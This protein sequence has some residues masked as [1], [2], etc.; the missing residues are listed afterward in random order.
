MDRKDTKIWLLLALIFITIGTLTFATENWLEQRHSANQRETVFNNIG[1]SRARL[2]S[3]L[4]Q[5]LY[6]L[7]ALSTYIGLHPNISEQEYTRY[8][9]SSLPSNSVI[10]I[11]AA[12]PELVVKYIYPYVG[13]EQAIGLNYREHRDQREAVF[14]AIEQRDSVLAGPVE[15]VQGGTGFVARVPVFVAAN[16]PPADQK[17]WGIVAA[18]IPE[19]ILYAESGF[20][21]NEQ[22]IDIALRGRDASGP[23]G[24]VFFGD[25]GLFDPSA[26]SILL[27]IKVASGE[28]Q[29]AAQPIGGWGLKNSGLVWS[30][31]AGGLMIAIGLFLGFRHRQKLSEQTEEA[32]RNFEN[33][34]EM[35]N[36]GLFINDVETLNILNM[37]QSGLRQL[38]YDPGEMIG[39]SALEFAPYQGVEDILAARETLSQQT[40]IVFET[41]L[42]R[43]DGT[44]V[45]VELSTRKVSRPDGDIAISA[46]RDISERKAVEA[47]LKKSRQDLISAIEAINAG[48]ALW[49]PA[50]KLQIFNQ[51]YINLNP[52]LKEKVKVGIS[53]RELLAYTYDMELVSTDF[54]RDE[55]IEMRIADHKDPKGPYEFR[56]GDGRFVKISEYLTPDGSCVAIYEDITELKRATEHVHYRAYFDVLTGLPNRE[57]FLG[58]LTETLVAIQRTEQ[59][60][61]LLFVDLDRFKN[62]NDT[63]GHAIGDNLL[64]E[65][66]LRLRVVVRQTDFVA[67]FA[68]DEFVV[69]LRYIEEPI[70]AAHIAENL[71]AKLSAPYQVD[72]HE[73]YCSA[74]IGIAV[75]PSDTLEAETLL[76]YADLAMYQAKA[77]GGNAFRFFTANMTERAQ[78]F[79][80]IEKDLRQAIKEDQCQLHYQPVFDLRSNELCSVEALVRWEHPDFGLMLPDEFISIAE[81]TSFIDE[82]GRWV[83]SEATKKAIDWRNRENQ[84][85]I[86]VAVNV[87]SRQFWG[88]FDT[89]FVRNLLAEA[90]FPAERLNIEIT[91]SIVMGDEERIIRVLEDLR[92]LG[93]GIC[94]DDFGTGYSA[95]SYLKRLPV[96]MLKIDRS[97]VTD[98][99]KSL[100]DA[101]LVE[102]IIAMAKALRVRVVAEGIETEPQLKILSEMGCDFGQGL[103]FGEPI[104]SLEFRKRFLTPNVVQLNDR[105]RGSKR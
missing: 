94:I 11:V 77:I 8:V 98:I 59:V 10:S 42:R 53:F 105:H 91:E 34:F 86:Q 73:V 40:Q 56:S 52:Q 74:S 54:Q 45:P 67:R 60:A 2:E 81:E 72:G 90:D 55:W 93:V 95:I 51:R 21:S 36:D 25:A 84:K 102:S 79:V 17:L 66:A 18:V 63:L 33:L 9:A 100:D 48:F 15:L 75:A 99:E 49:D 89:R 20:A 31:R 103:L 26:E 19:E 3:L 78:R 50:G 57:N 41:L 64:R 24:P 85:P 4:G 47:A 46:V 87:S 16:E 62:T 70:N 13:N 97:F 12:A 92:D 5:Q 58:K 69:L 27:P 30:I 22:E 7:K 101:L 83:I 14:L 28:W 6:T 104:D 39:R 43:K 76:S 23:D 68:G 88:D 71:L 80:T 61:A 32:Q 29:L 82:L 35:N 44:H 1:I 65:V 37:N 96:T 38:G